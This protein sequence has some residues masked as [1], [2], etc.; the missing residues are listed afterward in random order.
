VIIRQRF[1]LLLVDRVLEASDARVRVL[2]NVSFNEKVFLGH[3]PGQPIYPAVYLIEGMCQTAQILM[4]ARVA[5]TAKLDDFKFSRK[6]LPGDQ[7]IFEVTRETRLGRFL[8]ASASASVDGQVVARGRVVGASLD[9]D[10]TPAPGV[11]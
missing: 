8:T 2:K 11:R 7:V 4:G 10:P 6:V 3:F 5:V 9:D 1:P